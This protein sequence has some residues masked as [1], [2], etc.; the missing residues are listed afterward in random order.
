MKTLFTALL[1]LGLALIAQEQRPFEKPR[2]VSIKT[3]PGSPIIVPGCKVDVAGGYWER[4][5]NTPTY[6]P[7]QTAAERD[8]TRN[9]TNEEIG[10]NVRLDLKAGRIVTIYP[11]EGGVFVTE[12][13]QTK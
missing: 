12:E 4:A 3:L 1:V 2:I 9:L 10:R 13:C 7:P 6:R 5:S 8:C 11:D